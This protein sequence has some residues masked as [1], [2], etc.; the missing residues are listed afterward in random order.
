M[1]VKMLRPRTT[2]TAAFSGD[3]QSLDSIFGVLRICM[4]T[5][6]RITM[7][8]VYPVNCEEVTY[9]IA[10]YPVSEATPPCQESCELV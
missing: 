8:D 3:D 1:A 2:L 10:R 7:L 9:S 6:W 4:A 5:I